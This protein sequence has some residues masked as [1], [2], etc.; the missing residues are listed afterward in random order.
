MKPVQREIRD[1][2]HLCPDFV[3]CARL[4]WT[5]TVGKQRVGQHQPGASLLLNC[6]LIAR[7][8]TPDERAM[9]S[10]VLFSTAETFLPRFEKVCRRGT[11]RA[12]QRFA[13][14]SV[15]GSAGISRRSGAIHSA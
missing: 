7:R 6:R 14:N 11:E 12:S 2:L 8:A 9:S 15:Q 10:M 4:S 1:R 13:S 3:V 5:H